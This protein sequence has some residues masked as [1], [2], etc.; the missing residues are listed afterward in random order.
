MDTLD[1][2]ASPLQLLLFSAISLY[3]NVYIWYLFLLIFECN[4]VPT[5]KNKAIELGISDPMFSVHRHSWAHWTFYINWGILSGVARLDTSASWK[6]V[7]SHWLCDFPSNDLWLSQSFPVS[8]IVNV[9]VM[10]LRIRKCTVWHFPRFRK[11]RMFD[12]AF[13]VFALFSPNTLNMS[14]LHKWQI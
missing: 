7:G 6:N 1:P 9:N 14:K 2:T 4:Y 10:T 12:V 3:H 13:P 5:F 8:R 11:R